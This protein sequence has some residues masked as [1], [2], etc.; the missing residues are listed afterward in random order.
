MRRVAI[1]LLLQRRFEHLGKWGL[2]SFLH[3]GIQVRSKSTMPSWGVAVH[4]GHANETA[5]IRSP[6]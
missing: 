2:V 4:D 1:V 5:G 6:G 3:Q